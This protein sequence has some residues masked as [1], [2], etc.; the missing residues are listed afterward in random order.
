MLQITNAQLGSLARWREAGFV[1]ALCRM[2]E[3]DFAAWRGRPEAQRQLVTRALAK[4]R[5]LG[6]TSRSDLRSWTQLCATHGLELERQPWATRVLTDSALEPSEKLS[7]LVE[8][9]VFA[10]R[11]A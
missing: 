5:G 2:L 7:L 8:R 11:A 9:A 6:L 1:E 4:G 10:G 3:K